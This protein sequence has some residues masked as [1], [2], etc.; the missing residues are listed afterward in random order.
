MITA[1]FITFGVQI[2]GYVGQQGKN[3]IPA[4]QSKKY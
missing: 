3:K 1:I 2:L 4:R